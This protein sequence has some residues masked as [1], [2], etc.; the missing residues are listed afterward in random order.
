MRLIVYKV[1]CCAA[2]LTIAVV[3]Y[4]QDAGRIK[5][6]DNT[7]FGMSLG[8]VVLFAGLAYKVG[9]EAQRNSSHI[10]NENIHQSRAEIMEHFV[11]VVDCKT[12]NTGLT[13]SMAAIAKTLSEIKERLARIETATNGKK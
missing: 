9:A 12:M 8:L 11:S 13:G 6:E 10:A 5:L 7:Q 3:A 2:L 1:L 4:A